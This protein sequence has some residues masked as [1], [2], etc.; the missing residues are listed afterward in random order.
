M[1]RFELDMTRFELVVIGGGL[2]AARAIKE[3]RAAGGGGRVALL[4]KERE[5]PYHRPPLSKRYLRGEAER[6]ETLVEPEAFY[7]QNQVELLLA[8]EASR[9]APREQAVETRDGRRP[10]ANARRR[11]GAP[12]GRL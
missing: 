10:A 12:P 9:I 7:A 3:Y 5:L 2:A 6:A 4:T 8:N 11:G 1:T